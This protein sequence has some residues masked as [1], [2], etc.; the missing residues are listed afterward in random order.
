MIKEGELLSDLMSLFAKKDGIQSEAER[1]A[2]DMTIKMSH[3][4][5]WY[6]GDPL[7]DETRWSVFSEKVDALIEECHQNG[8]H[9]HPDMLSEKWVEGVLAIDE[10]HQDEPFLDKLDQKDIVRHFFNGGTQFG[11]ARNIQKQMKQII[12]KEEQK[13]MDR[14]GKRFNDHSDA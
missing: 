4:F 13:V 1:K 7:E 9:K 8:W 3:A 11:L 2:T 10:C 14:A 12:R 6:D 5:P